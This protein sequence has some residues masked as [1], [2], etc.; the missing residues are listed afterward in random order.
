MVSIEVKVP[1]IIFI[2][3]SAPTKRPHGMPPRKDPTKGSPHK[4]LD[5][6]I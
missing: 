2:Y 1:F 4:T 3:K 6:L 5:Y